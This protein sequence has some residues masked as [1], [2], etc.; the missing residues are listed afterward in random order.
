MI[1]I[2]RTPP[3]DFS[4]P[5][6]SPSSRKASR[7]SSPHRMKL[8]S[9]RVTS[10]APSE[11]VRPASTVQLAQQ[12]GA[13][14]ASSHAPA[15]PARLPACCPTAPALPSGLSAA[16]KGTDRSAPPAAVHRA[17]TDAAAPHF[18]QVFPPSQHPSG[19]TNPLSR[20]PLLLLP[21]LSGGCYCTQT[22]C[23][24]ASR[25]PATPA[26]HRL[27]H[28]H[29]VR[30]RTRRETC[31]LQPCRPPPTAAGRL[32]AHPFACEAAEV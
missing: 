2:G 14:N 30:S 23:V 20:S 24:R 32:V 17:G 5:I 6:N 27:A 7:E 13:L 18:V 19:T 26:G 21:H 4:S 9:S 28:L 1:A 22:R 29:L 12:P 25:I 16:D 15:D 3:P 8:T 11:A 31:G 10:R